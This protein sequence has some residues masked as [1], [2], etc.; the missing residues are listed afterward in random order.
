MHRE[1]GL[2]ERRRGKKGE[3]RKGEERG[4]GEIG[5]QSFKW[6]VSIQSLPSELRKPYGI[7][8]RKSIIAKG[9]ENHQ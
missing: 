9:D 4:R 3:E 2:G 5:I 1:R 7:G 6:D 8:G